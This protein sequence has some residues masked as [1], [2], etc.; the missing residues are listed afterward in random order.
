MAKTRYGRLKL[1]IAGLSAAGIIAGAAVLQPGPGASA[2]ND[3]SAL[4]ENPAQAQAANSVAASS[5]GATTAHQATAT[6]A[7]SSGGSTTQSTRSVPK[8]RVS[9]G[10]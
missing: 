7:P 8:A 10:S 2:A 6:A 3:N 5:S 9:R 4:A 1:G